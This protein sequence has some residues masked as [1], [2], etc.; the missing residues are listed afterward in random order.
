MKNSKRIRRRS[1]KD[2]QRLY[3]DSAHYWPLDVLPF[4]AAAAC[5]D[6]VL[7]QSHKA[8]LIYRDAKRVFGMCTLPCVPTEYLR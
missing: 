6:V 3:G 8:D 7:E 4:F 5:T 1:T 2:T